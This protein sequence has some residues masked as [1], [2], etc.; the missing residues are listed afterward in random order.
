MSA[1]PVTN[2][3]VEDNATGGYAAMDWNNDLE[4]S[5]PP[6]PRRSYSPLMFNS[7]ESTLRE[8]IKARIANKDKFFSLEYFPPRTK[9]GAI[10]LLARLERMGMGQPLFI[11]V[12]W[13]PAG[14]PSG[15]TE[16]SSMMIAHSA[17][18]Y[19]GLETM[20]H[21]TCA[22]STPSQMKEY[23]EK[24]KRLDIK[25]IFIGPAGGRP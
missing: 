7:F 14:N 12:T 19:V 24:A 17:L 10:N 4:N 15:D 18:N 16:T 23:L 20:L 8:K 9:S 1:N 13:H 22:G 6:T 2:G 5:T 3:T 21:M 25:N 11:D